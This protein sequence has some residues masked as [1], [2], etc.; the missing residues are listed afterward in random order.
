MGQRLF[1]RVAVL[2]LGTMRIERLRIAFSVT[3]TSKPEPNKASIKV[4]GLSDAHRAQL[5]EQAASSISTQLEA[6]Y[7]SGTS[8]IYRGDLRRC[9][10]MREQASLVT[11]IETSDGALQM[12]SSRVSVSVQAGATNRDV[13][14]KVA[15]A[16]G[17]SDGNLSDAL[18][19]LGGAS[20]FLNGGVFY[21]SAAD[22]MTRLCR[23]LDLTWSIQDGKLQVLGRRDVVQGVAIRLSKDTGM[24][25]EPSIDPK[26]KLQVNMLMQPDVFP[27]RL[28][29]LDGTRLKG[30]FKI[31][32]TVHSG[33]TRGSGPWQI[34]C[35]AEAY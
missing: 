13:L 35:Q 27:G 15:R 30:N 8:V 3:K 1:D 4:W 12:Q 6:G 14:A 10:T 20:V 29:K 26:G 24:I 5:V 17:V 32:Q 11:T 23:S 34:A 2:T 22:E 21:G 28:I 31:E 7:A 33:D 9:F 19:K 16:V 18:S 25:N